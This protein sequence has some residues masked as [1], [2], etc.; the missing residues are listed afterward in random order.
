MSDTPKTS[1]SAYVSYISMILA[2]IFAI[3]DNLFLGYFIWQHLGAF[4]FV[5]MTLLNTP[6]TALYRYYS[7]SNFYQ[8]CKET[9]W[10]SIVAYISSPSKWL[11]LLFFAAALTG[12]FFLFN[13]YY[14]ALF[15]QILKLFVTQMG[16]TSS[17]GYYLTTSLVLCSVVPDAMLS[18]KDLYGKFCKLFNRDTYSDLLADEKGYI[19]ALLALVMICSF[20]FA[21]IEFSQAINSYQHFLI[22]VLQVFIPYVA[23]KMLIFGCIFINIFTQLYSM[24]VGFFTWVHTFNRNSAKG[25]EVKSYWELFCL[26]IIGTS[27]AIGQFLMTGE[28]ASNPFNINA[29][30]VAIFKSITDDSRCYVS[31]LNKKKEHSQLVEM[32]QVGLVLMTLSFLVLGCAHVI[33]L[34]MPL[35]LLSSLAGLLVSYFYPRKMMLILD[36]PVVG[37]VQETKETGGYS[38]VHSSASHGPEGRYARP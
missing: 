18:V 35:L 13:I 14:G 34:S 2:V 17:A 12:T 11:Y 26:L 5:A 29:Q 6:I 38:R 33:Q 4:A 23:N 3:V 9:K 7:Y 20:I 8:T 21:H 1:D 32:M 22:E 30:R 24:I 25:Y 15:I 31:G 27:R 28:L 16:L 10:E 36:Q 19:Y 37:S